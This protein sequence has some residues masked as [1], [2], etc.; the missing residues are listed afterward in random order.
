MIVEA[1]HGLTNNRAYIFFNNIPRTQKL[2][3]NEFL[4]TYSIE[5]LT[6]LYALTMSPSTTSIPMELLLFLPR[7]FLFE[8]IFDF[9][10]YWTHRLIHTYPIAYNYIHRLHHD[11]PLINS[12]NTFRH[13]ILDMAIT[14]TFPFL[15]AMYL[16]P[17]PR[18]TLVLLFWLKN[19]IEVSGHTGKDT[20]SSFIQ[21]IY[22]PRSLGI[23][24][25]SRDH[26]LHHFNPRVNF[27]KRFSIWD[28]V[29]GTFKSGE[30]LRAVE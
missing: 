17:V 6:F 22:L 20:T 16:C 1:L 14:N 13:T 27:S 9:F 24:I 8:L 26:S 30:T 10:H 15:T 28:K 25:Y 18:Y 11:N 12:Y 3:I 7:S 23:E 19:I 5:G 2:D 21:C 4:Q 29:F